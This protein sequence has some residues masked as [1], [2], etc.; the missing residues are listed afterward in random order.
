MDRMVRIAVNTTLTAPP[1]ERELRF[2]AAGLRLVISDVDGT[3]TD[4]TVYYSERGEAMKRFSMRDGM[5]VERLRA[6]G[7]ETAF[8]T[9]ERSPIVARRAEKLQIQHLHQ[10]VADKAHALAGILAQA[11]CD[12][13]QVAYIGD[14]LNDLEAMRMVSLKGLVAAP[15][16]AMPQVLHVAHHRCGRPGGAG[17]FR[18]FAEWILG[19][20]ELARRPNIFDTSVLDEMSEQEGGM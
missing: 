10:G 11:R 8:L 16:D 18:E 9:R 19:L 2:R 13:S 12:L 14:D 15:L 20:R 3:L 5:G 4:G 1:L 17:A 7:I 6:D